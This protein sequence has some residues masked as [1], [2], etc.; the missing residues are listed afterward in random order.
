MITVAFH[1]IHRRSD[2]FERP[3][4][5]RPERFIDRKYSPY[6]WVPFGGGTRRCIGMHFAMLE[7]KLVLAAMVERFRIEIAQSDVKPSWRG[8]FLTPN[9]GLIVRACAAQ[10]LSAVTTGSMTAGGL[11][12][13]EFGS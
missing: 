7:M 1:A 3:D 11:G 12:V 13:G 8:A 5:F 2:V 6:E 9:K 4:Q 10:P